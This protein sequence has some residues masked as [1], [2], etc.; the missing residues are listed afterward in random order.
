VIGLEHH[1]FFVG[2]NFSRHGAT[3]VEHLQCEYLPALE[4]GCLPEKRAQQ[5][6]LMGLRRRSM[7]ASRSQ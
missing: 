3:L 7:A 6:L 5:P 1:G 4:L 2:P